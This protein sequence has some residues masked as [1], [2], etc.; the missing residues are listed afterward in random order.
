MAWE[1]FRLRQPN[2]YAKTYNFAGSWSSDF[3][4]TTGSSTVANL[5]PALKQLLNG[6]IILAWSSNETGSYQLYYKTYNGNAWTS[7][8]RLTTGSFSDYRPDIV[9]APDG[10][11]WLFWYRQT[12]SGSCTSGFC[13]HVYFKTL[14]GNLWS[15]ETQMTTDG[16]WNIEPDVTAAKDGHLLVAFSKWI[17]SG[18][19]GDWNVYYRK[20]DGATW[21]GDLLLAT[22]ANWDM[23]PNLSQDRNGTI[24]LFWA[25]EM[26]LT[27]SAYQDKVWYKF[28]PDEGTTWS[29]D[30]QLTFGGN[31][32][33][34]IDDNE[35][36]AV[37][38]RDKSLWIFYSSDA[39]GQGA[40]FDI[41]YIKTNPI[42]P[43]H[44][45]A[46]AGLQYPTYQYRG[47]LAGI[48]QSAL[49]KLN[50]TVANNGDFAENAQ[51]SLTVSSTTSYSLGTQTV[52]IAAG[53]SA[54][55]T[56]SW[57]TTSVPYG[58]YNLA[59]AVS[60]APGESSLNTP[61]NNLSKSKAFRVGPWGDIDQDGAV[62]LI[63]ASIV[64]L[65]FGSTPGSPRWTPLGDINGSGVIDIIDE[66]IV[67]HNFGLVT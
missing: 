65:G 26:K 40:D 37:Q 20:F 35:P 50:V 44:D 19:S 62:T 45:L 34:T 17:P 4:I 14:T 63:D 22:N 55:V 29:T 52:S 15:A 48:G 1:S 64:F 13:R 6:T 47:G 27:Q 24:W 12:A 36:D 51:V 2:V 5:Q 16:T 58:L 56:F 31:S 3:N 42:T 38:A 39:T 67:A 53:A 28:S 43:I 30:R 23:T 49:A 46:A 54:V 21:T 8:V 32:T 41:Y 61:D 7:K 60:P 11:L 18:S 33:V 25:R 57:D 59:A 9:V 66:G 10:K